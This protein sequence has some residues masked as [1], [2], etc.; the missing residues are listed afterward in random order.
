[1][2]MSWK[3]AK[4]YNDIT[5]KK[6]DGIARIAFNRPEV[7]NAFRPETLFELQEAL[8]DAREDTSIGVV[9]A[10]LRHREEVPGPAQGDGHGDGGH[11]EQGDRS[12]SCLLSRRLERGVSLSPA[13]AKV[14]V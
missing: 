13:G 8:I 2:T 3:T 9:L 1:M 10:G 14:P 11:D 5:Y 6:M 7:R 4:E 12:Q